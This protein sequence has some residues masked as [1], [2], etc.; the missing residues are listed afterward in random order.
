MKFYTI[1]LPKFLGGFVKAILNT[2]QKINSKQPPSNDCGYSG[3]WL[4]VN[5]C[6]LASG[7]RIGL[8]ERQGRRNGL[9]RIGRRS[10]VSA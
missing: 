3:C 2:F 9:R 8:W 6:R 1:K 10:G 4:R 5:G 7:R